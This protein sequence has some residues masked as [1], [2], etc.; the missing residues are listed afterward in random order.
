MH[1]R[2]LGFVLCLG[3]IMVTACNRPL[4]NQ[5]TQTQTTP[6]NPPSVVTGTSEGVLSSG[7]VSRHYLLHIP[8]TYQAGMAVPLVINFH[9]FN[10]N[11]R[12]EENLTGMS[13]KADQENFI[14]VYPDGLNSTWYPGHGAEGE[15]DLRFIR[16]LITWIESHYT[17]EGWNNPG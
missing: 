17:I 2:Q 12:Q 14:V 5:V 13:A 9:G 15:A 11:S 4:R 10:S 1:Y 7:G 16:E 8:A 3:L 6:S